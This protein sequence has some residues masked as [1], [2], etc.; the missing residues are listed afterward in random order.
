[1]ERDEGVTGGPRVVGHPVVSYHCVVAY[2]QV[3]TLS[4]Y[5]LTTYYPLII[6]RHLY[7]RAV[8]TH[9]YARLL[10]KWEKRE[11]SGQDMARDAEMLFD[12]VLGDGEEDG[13][14]NSDSGSG[15]NV[16]SSLGAMISYPIKL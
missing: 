16:L 7:E 5:S 13:D 15:G 9:T 2:C 12:S 14:S 10:S 6:R 8:L 1:M 4:H 3:L 11:A